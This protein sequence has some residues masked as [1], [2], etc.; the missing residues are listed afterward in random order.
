MLEIE[1]RI[2]IGRRGQDSIEFDH[3]ELNLPLSPGEETSFTV[4]IINYTIPTHVH[5]AVSRELKGFLAIINDNPY[6]RDAEKIPVV[7]RLPRDSGDGTY[8]G[9]IHVISGY[10]SVK[11][12]FTVTIGAK[13]G[14]IERKDSIIEKDPI[15]VSMPPEQIKRNKI[16]DKVPLRVRK[17]KIKLPEDVRIP[18]GITSSIL[19]LL[20]YIFVFNPSSIWASLLASIGVALLVFYIFNIYRSQG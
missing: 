13:G 20:V 6:V 14:K 18:V 4:A 16:R 9:K 11:G 7:A 3:D 8:S 2:H 17:A 12:S 5:L 15:K 19:I 10:G 1:Q